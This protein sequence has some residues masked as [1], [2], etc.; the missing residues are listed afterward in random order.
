LHWFQNG[1]PMK[2]VNTQHEAML[3]VN[4]DVARAFFKKW[5]RMKR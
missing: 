5:Y 3:D 2:T 4:E 1:H